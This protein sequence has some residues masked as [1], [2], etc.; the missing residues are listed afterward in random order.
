M[1]QNTLHSYHDLALVDFLEFGWPINYVADS[2]PQPVNRNH[3]SAIKHASAVRNF[4]NNEVN[5]QATAGPFQSNPLD[6]Q[7]MI[8]PLLTVPKKDSIN[9]RVV[10]DLSYPPNCS[11]NDGVPTTP[12]LVSPLPFAYLESTLWF[13]SFRSSVLAACCLRQISAVLTANC[14]LILVTTTLLF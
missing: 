4:I 11:V 1:W 9:H 12:F 2:L 6:C 14:P 7:L 3:P 5:L 13:K 8:S 10:M